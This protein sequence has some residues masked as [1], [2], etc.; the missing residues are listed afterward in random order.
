MTATA[1]ASNRKA[2][3]PNNPGLTRSG[4]ISGFS[5]KKRINLFNMV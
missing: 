2:N 3:K 5:A 1:A 4:S